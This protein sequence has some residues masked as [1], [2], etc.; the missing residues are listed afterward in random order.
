MMRHFAVVEGQG[1][2][3]GRKQCKE[4]NNDVDFHFHCDS[5]GKPQVEHRML[6]R[7]MVI[8]FVAAQAPSDSGSWQTMRGGESEGKEVEDECAQTDS[9]GTQS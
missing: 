7:A 5:K 3:L 4:K 1:E 6:T 8:P 2:E 9:E